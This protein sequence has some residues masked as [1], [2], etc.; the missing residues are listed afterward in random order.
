MRSPARSRMHISPE[1]ARASRQRSPHDRQ[2]DRAASISSAPTTSSS[3]SRGVG[4]VVH[5]AS[6]RRWRVLPLARRR[7]SRSRPKSPEDAIRLYGFLSADEREWFRLLQTVQG[8]GARVGLSIL[9]ALK[10]DRARARGRARRQ[11][12]RRPR[13]RRGPEARHPHRH[14]AEGQGARR[15]RFSAAPMRAIALRLAGARG[16]SKRDAIAALVKLGYSQMVAG[17][18]VRARRRPP[19]PNSAALTA[20]M[21]ESADAQLA[22]ASLTLCSSAVFNPWSK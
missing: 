18:A 20:L 2:A 14:R 15:W 22:R 9:S 21:R 1:R 6:R 7:A 4:Y 11:D 3:M 8:V 19:R 16:R 10:T 12:G 17:D 13:A 5:C